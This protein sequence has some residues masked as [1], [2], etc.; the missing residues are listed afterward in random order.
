V[1]GV[2]DLVGVQVDHLDG[3][4]PVSRPELMLLGDHEHSVGAGVV[5]VGSSIRIE[6]LAREAANAAQEG[7]VLGVD[8]I[9]AGIALAL[10][11]NP[12]DIEE[13]QLLEGVLR[14][15]DRHLDGAQQGEIGEV[16]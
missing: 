13:P 5:V 10:C 8:D 14:L 11:V 1:D 2:D 7:V 16:S 3:T 12:A 6:R 9:D 4:V 15:V